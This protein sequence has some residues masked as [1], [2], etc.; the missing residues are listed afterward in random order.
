MGLAVAEF[1]VNALKHRRGVGFIAMV[2][3][4]YAD[5]GQDNSPWGDRVTL[6][7]AWEVN[8]VVAVRRMLLV[9]A[10]KV[11]L[12]NV[13]TCAGTRLH[14][15]HA[16]QAGHPVRVGHA[17]VQEGFRAAGLHA[18]DFGFEDRVAVG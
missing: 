16:R 4:G 9:K 10:N 12:G 2:Q 14:I 7:Q 18:I 15:R 11:V 5:A 8:Q 1:K 17:A 3:P 13:E 6:A